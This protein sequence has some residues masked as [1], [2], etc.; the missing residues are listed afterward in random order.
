MV[1]KFAVLISVLVVLLSVAFYSTQFSSEIFW[2]LR[3]PR[4]MTACLAGGAVALSG[5]LMQSYFQNPLAG[6]DILGIHSGATLFV[7]MWFMFFHKMSGVL[8]TLG[9][10]GSALLG[11]FMMMFVISGLAKKIGNK[12]LLVLLGLFAS[13]LASG[14]LTVGLNFA[15]QDHIKAILLWSFGTFQRTTLSDLPFL[16]LAS[17]I[18][19]LLAMRMAPHLD[20][21][22]LG[23][24]YA[25]LSGMNFKKISLQIILLTGFSTGLVVAFC[26]PVAFIGL[27]AIHLSKMIFK[28]ER[29]GILIPISFL[30]GAI[31]ALTV[32]CINLGMAPQSLPLNALLG[33]VGAPV[34]LLFIYRLNFRHAF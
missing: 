23:E 15:H 18:P 27:A 3:F 24:T 21:L 5:L 13:Q 16:V 6:P 2:F 14:L 10:I 19:L 34:I 26:G 32:E 12:M 7:A 29:H 20:L 17:I 31:M 8:A 9:P 1:K 22:H 4:I 30:I 28:T 25:R 33:I 11:S